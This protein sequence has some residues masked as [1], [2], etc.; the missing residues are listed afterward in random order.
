MA[1]LG[2]LNE[3]FGMEQRFV[4]V[5]R[6]HRFGKTMADEVFDGLAI[7]RAEDFS[8][9]RGACDVLRINMQELLSR[10]NDAEAL[11]DRLRRILLRDLVRAYP[12]VDYFDKTDLLK[13][14]QC[15]WE[16]SSVCASHVLPATWHIPVANII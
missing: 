13:R 2:V 14:L 16:K 9:Y 3:V 8:R 15:V 11:I 6:P 5:S 7:A 12:K 10:I 1:L 4:C